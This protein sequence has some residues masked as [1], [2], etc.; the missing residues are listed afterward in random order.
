MDAIEQV[1]G[2]HDSPGLFPFYDQFKRSEI[3]LPERSLADSG[4]TV[5]PVC[6]L[7][8]H[9]EMLYA[10]SD[11]LALDAVHHRSGAKSRKERILGIILEVSSAQR[12]S[13]DIDRRSKPYAAVIFLHL[14]RSSSTDLLKQI[15]VPGAGKQRRTGPRRRLDPCLGLDSESGSPIRCHGIRN[16]VPWKIAP[17]KRIGDSGI[18]LSPCQ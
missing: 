12:A 1:V 16:F 9:A 2:R 7:I 13:V 6:L 18:R 3:D 8:V 14:F 11:L 17:A 5:S 4:I 10:G 15:L